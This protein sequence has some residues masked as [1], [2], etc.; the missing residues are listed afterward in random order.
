VVKI[1]VTGGAGYIGSHMC[2]MLAEAGHQPF[3]F[4]NLSTGHAEAVQWGSHL[5]GDLVDAERV[6]EVFDEVRPDGVIHFA[7]KSLVG[8]S[9]AQ[10]GLYYRNNVSGALNVVEQVR[11]RPGCAFVLSSTCAIFGAAQKPTIDETHPINPINPYGSSKRMVEVQ[12]ADFWSAYRMPSMALRYFN[13]AGADPS[14]VIGES[15]HPETHLIP[16]LLEAALGRGGR[17]QVLGTDYPTA[18]GTCI[19]DYVHVN[20]LCRA[21]LQGLELMQR[22]PGCYAFNLGIGRGFS[23][24]QV[25]DSAASVIGRAVDFERAPRRSGDPPQLVADSTRAQQALGWQPQYTTL[26]SIIETAWRWHR[27]RRF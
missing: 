17:L 26:E 3:V 15:H 4:D 8:E 23:V 22:E 2:K 6:R 7:A 11:H 27:D 12:L 9:V 10:P 25:I 1:L 13:A 5:S 21:H 20:D 14:G 18:D 24:Q 19:R 16:N